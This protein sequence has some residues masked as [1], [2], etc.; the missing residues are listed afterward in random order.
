M[1]LAETG[2]FEQAVALQR[3]LIAQAEAEADSRF[4]GRLRQN[5]ERYERGEPSR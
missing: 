2:E 4:V 5:L 3:S 1:A